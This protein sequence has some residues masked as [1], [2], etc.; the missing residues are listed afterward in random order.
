MASENLQLTSAR[1]VKEIALYDGEIKN[2]VPKYVLEMFKLK[3]KEKNA[4]IL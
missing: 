4:K 1:F 2:F 3:R